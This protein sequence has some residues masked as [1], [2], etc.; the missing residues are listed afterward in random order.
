MSL[1][2][3]VVKRVLGWSMGTRLTLPTPCPFPRRRHNQNVAHRDIKP[4]NIL[5]DKETGQVK[6]TDF[7]VSAIFEGKGGNTDEDKEIDLTKK[8]AGTTMFMAPEVRG[9]EGKR[10]KDRPLWFCLNRERE[11]EREREKNREIEK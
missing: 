5:I 4:G 10:R 3:W 2:S 1:K 6:I 7:G 8:T 11:R 9:E